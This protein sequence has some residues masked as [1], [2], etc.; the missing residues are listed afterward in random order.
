MAD[1]RNDERTDEEVMK[2]KQTNIRKRMA[3]EKEEK[4]AKME[5]RGVLRSEVPR[6]IFGCQ[7]EID[8]HAGTHSANLEGNIV[9]ASSIIVAKY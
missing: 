5:G 6:L 2:K 3:L 9:P 7:H 4:E 1:K 8:V